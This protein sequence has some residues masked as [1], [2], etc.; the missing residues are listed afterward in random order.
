M[1]L[2][3]RGGQRRLKATD[4]RLKGGNGKKARGWRLQ[5]EGRLKAVGFRPKGEDNE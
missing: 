5:G 4:C 3:K 1:S 2:H